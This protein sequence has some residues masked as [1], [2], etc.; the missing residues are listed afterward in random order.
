[1]E[2]IREEDVLAALAEVP[3]PE[4]GISIVDLGLIYGIDISGDN[5]RIRM[6]MTTP[7]C[8][9]HTHLRVA[10]DEAVRRHI[11]EV[12]SVL[13]ELVWDPPWH[14]MLISPQARRQL[15]WPE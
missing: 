15:G 9:L 4:I 6:T 12:N 14:P 13:V 10:V 11:P 2:T 8:P 3:D 7:A 1:M 5:I